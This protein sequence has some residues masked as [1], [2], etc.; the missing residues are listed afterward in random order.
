[1]DEIS[2]KKCVGTYLHA[3]ITLNVG[4][5][6]HIMTFKL[7]IPN[8]TSLLLSLHLEIS[9]VNKMIASYDFNK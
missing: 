8:S 7:R 2:Q 5:S 3:R 6:L 9:N 4:I 1:M